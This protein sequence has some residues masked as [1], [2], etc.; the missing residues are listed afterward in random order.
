LYFRNIKAKALKIARKDFI[1]NMIIDR[2]GVML[3][4]F[5]IPREFPTG[6]YCRREKTENATINV[7][8]IEEET[9]FSDIF[10]LRIFEVKRDCPVHINLPLYKPPSEK[11]QMILRFYNCP[12]EDRTIDK[13]V[14]YNNVRVIV[15]T[16]LNYI[17]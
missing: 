5:D 6:F 4:K 9:L 3:E 15:Q 12:L 16:W 17:F 11:E 13:C 7:K 14:I 10:H 1:Q 2:V 8:K